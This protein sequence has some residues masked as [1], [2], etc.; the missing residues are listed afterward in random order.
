MLDMAVDYLLNFP[1]ALNGGD[2]LTGATA[3]V[4][5][6]KLDNEF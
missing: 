4:T 5:K 2:W 6:L 3:L 1:S